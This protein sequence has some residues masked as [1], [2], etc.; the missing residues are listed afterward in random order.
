MANSARYASV[1]IHARPDRVSFRQTGSS[2]KEEHHTEGTEVSW[3]GL[4][5]QVKYHGSEHH[6]ERQPRIASAKESI[7]RITV[8]GGGFHFP[9][10]T[11]WRC[12]VVTGDKTVICDSRSFHLFL[13]GFS[14]GPERNPSELL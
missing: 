13:I 1:Q 12:G 2:E 7:S 4:K 9:T 6:S 14:R 8:T 5:G 11:S 10:S 3:N